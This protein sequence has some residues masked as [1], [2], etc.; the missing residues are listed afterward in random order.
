MERQRNKIDRTKQLLKIVKKNEQTSATENTSPVEENSAQEK[1]VGLYA[2]PDGV[3]ERYDENGE[4]T[5]K[6][7]PGGVMEYYKNGILYKMTFPNGT[8]EEF[9]EQGKKIEN[10]AEEKPEESKMASKKEVVQKTPE[11][12]IN[13][14][15][16]EFK[17]QELL[18]ARFE[19][20]YEAQK[21]KV[22]LDLKRR[23]VDIV[24]SDAQTQYSE[25]LKKET[26]ASVAPAGSKLSIILK[27]LKSLPGTALT[28]IKKSATKETDLKNL[29][30]KVFEE[31]R[32][33]DKGR[34]LIAA[35]MERLTELNK[36]RH[37]SLDD[38]GN[39]LVDYVNAH[40][41]ISDPS[42]EEVLAYTNFNTKANSFASVPY[43][44]GQEKKGKHKKEY[45]QIKFEYEQARNELLK[46][47]IEKA[48]KGEL[49]LSTKKN[50]ILEILE[51]DNAIQL[52]Q[53]L[54]THPE[55]EKALNNFGES[56]GGK[57][58]LK[59]AG[60]FLETLTGGKNLTNKLLTIGGFGARTAAKG[61]AVIS[62]T[63][64]IT[65]F[66]AP[67]IGGTIGGLRGK[68]RAKETLTERQ[69][70]AR[71]GKKDE[72][73]E[74]S[75]VV[76]AKKL[77][78]RLRDTVQA[79][80]KTVVGSEEDIKLLDQIKRRIEFTKNKIESGLVNFGETREALTNQYNLVN[81]L[82][83]AVVFSASLEK[84][85]RK[86]IDAR[87]DK[88]LS[89]RKDKIGEAQDA[90]IKEQFWRGV[91][92]GAGFATLGYA[93]R[94]IG[95]YTH[96]LGH[97]PV[98]A[99]AKASVAEHTKP[100]SEGFINKWLDKHHPVEKLELQKP[101]A[102]GLPGDYATNPA[103]SSNDTLNVSV[104]LDHGHGAIWGIKHLQDQ[105][106]EQY[107][108]LSKAP[109]NVQ[110]FVNTDATKEAIKLGLYDPTSTD[111][112]ALVGQG[113]VLK[114]D[115]SGN[116]SLHDTLTNKDDILIHADTSSVEKYHEGMFHSGVTHSTPT[117]KVTEI[118]PRGATETLPTETG[119]NETLKQHALARDF[120]VNNHPSES[121]TPT[122]EEL[123]AKARE[124]T[125][126]AMN[127]EADKTVLS[128]QNIDKTT[129]IN[130]AP[131]KIGGVTT[132]IPAGD[133][134]IN[135]SLG[136]LSRH[137]QIFA[138]V[139]E[140]QN[141]VLVEHLGL[142]DKKDISSLGAN[143]LVEICTKSDNNM[144]IL[145]GNNSGAMLELLKKTKA[146]AIESIKGIPDADNLKSYFTGLKT[147]S[148]IEPKNSFFGGG[149]TAEHYVGRALKKMMATG[150]LQDFED[151]VVPT[152]KK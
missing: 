131:Y 130:S 66:A 121:V 3:V 86:D 36:Y 47:K 54:N 17:L 18:P 11:E 59:T 65:A 98:E 91:R 115:A 118:P 94:F 140:G 34:K 27:T 62:G 77:S 8:A 72:S 30:N 105:L 151:K 35:D 96:I 120:G 129:P 21:L 103:Y 40:V 89:Y 139:T 58:M 43:E 9:D 116:L 60:N 12:E 95:E 104:T 63:T 10:N 107:P 75:D 93:V 33:T 52:E 71:H 1:R 136:L 49:F 143:R 26:T 106:K 81:D 92:Y 134:R 51:I 28:A 73:K 110:D 109:Q 67:V 55:F 127:T 25:E 78:K 7:I 69:V 5:S 85:T 108:D 61:A 19:N 6:I 111:E 87:L 119:L 147:A 46:I 45:E 57:E 114:F 113:S 14:F 133:S 125:L 37:V 22:V 23:I 124:K 44:W 15:I 53:L 150:K 41:E 74:A 88:F 132:V 4:L 82:N 48:E 128:A 80:K 122:A 76:D 142:I 97:A 83:E 31:L 84:T 64:M 32:D 144:R 135:H 145:F 70:G 39:P 29:E 146:G 149:E 38:S 112:S 123:V 50:V 152:L 24:K 148:G 137:P 2:A 13:D 56:A 79:C 117:E 138:G 16:S 102:P 90:F 101:K 68:I 42:K 20:L 100:H 126:A 99:T 141:S